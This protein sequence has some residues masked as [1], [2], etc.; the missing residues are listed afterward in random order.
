[1]R[2]EIETRRHGASD[3][4]TYELLDRR[5]RQIAARVAQGGPG[6]ILL[7]EVAAVITVGRR[8]SPD[9]L[10]MSAEF[11]HR[12]GIARV[13]VERGGFAT[14]HGPGQWVLFVVDRLERLTGDARGVRRMIDGLLEVACDVARPLD[15]SVETR[16]GAELGLW[17]R[18]GKIAALGIQVEQGIVLH[19]LALNGFRTPQSFLGLKPCGLDL[20]VGFLLEQ[21]PT[22]EQDLDHQFV[23]LGTALATRAQNRF[24]DVVSNS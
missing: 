3:P 7:S 24:F 4:W 19:G 17:T 23:A 11:L 10:P 20:P 1:M 5:Q 9:D 21:N 15:A 8:T 2:L 16:G 13:A 22:A 6:A 18:A 14:Y 12:H